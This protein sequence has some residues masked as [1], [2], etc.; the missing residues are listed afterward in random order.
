MALTELLQPSRQHLCAAHVFAD[1]DAVVVALSGEA[2]LFTLPAVMT[3]IGRA[4]SDHDGPVIVDLAGTSFVDI[5]T[6]HAL[7][8]AAER[9][10]DQD[11]ALTLRAASP[12]AARLLALVGRSQLIQ[13]D[14]TTA[15]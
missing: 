9:L 1:G 15:A 5:R 10:R 14:G 11:R 8:S 6:L 4:V 3:A 2:D 7:S 12:V 13:T